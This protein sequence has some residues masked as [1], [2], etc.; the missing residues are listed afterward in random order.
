MLQKIRQDYNINDLELISVSC[1][2]DSIA[3]IKKIAKLNMTWINI[4]GNADMRNKFGNKPIPSLYLIDP[5][6]IIKFSSWEDE[7]KKLHEILKENL[8]DK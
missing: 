7:E 1:D 4:F 5:N 3:F 6:G 2:K 8:R